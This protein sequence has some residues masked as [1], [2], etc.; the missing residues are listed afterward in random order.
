MDSQ[1]TPYYDRLCNRQFV[2]LQCANLLLSFVFYALVGLL[3]KLAAFYHLD[4]LALPALPVGQAAVLCLTVGMCLSGPCVG[5]LV[6]RYRR[7]RMFVYATALLG[8]GLLLL[9]L[10]V[11]H[12]LP[13]A[14][15]LP[16]CLASGMCYGVAGRVLTCILIIDKTESRNRTRAGLISATVSLCGAAL[17]VMSVFALSVLSMLYVEVA[18]AAALLLAIVCVR[19]LSF[20]FRAPIE[21]VRMVSLDRFFLPSAWPWF[22]FTALAALVAGM[23]VGGW[24][25]TQPDTTFLSEVLLPLVGYGLLATQMLGRMTQRGQ[26]CQRGTLLSTFFMA[27][28][29]GLPLGFV[30]AQVSF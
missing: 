19:V 6:E 20:P 13:P 8:I 21:G 18:L 27:Q 4:P 16:V 26:H 28:N 9:P 7:N 22:C 5:W 14:V 25:A 17:G 12:S 15:W 23:V 3:P 10:L 1:L 30:L 24:H 11:S 29:A 2:L